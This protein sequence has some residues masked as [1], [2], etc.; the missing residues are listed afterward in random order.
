MTIMSA[1]AH[2]SVSS[3]AAPQVALNDGRLAFSTVVNL[4]HAERYGMNPYVRL[5]AASAEVGSSPCAPADSD[6]CSLS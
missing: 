4:P 5:H 3:A 6:A 2:R 1:L